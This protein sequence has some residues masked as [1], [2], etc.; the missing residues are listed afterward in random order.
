MWVRGRSS[1]GW[2]EG[3]DELEMSHDEK[4]PATQLNDYHKECLTQLGE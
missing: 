3:R 2:V 4:M 1:G